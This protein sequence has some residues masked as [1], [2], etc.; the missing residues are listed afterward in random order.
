MGRDEQC[1]LPA[2]RIFDVVI[3]TE[4][5]WF[6]GPKGNLVF[7][8]HLFSFDKDEGTSVWDVATG[9]RLLRESSFCPQRYHPGTKSFLTVLPDD[10]FQISKLRGRTVELGWLSWNDRTVV[11]LA[12]AI[13]EEGAFD[14]LP[15]LADALE[16]AGCTDGEI[17][18][19]CRQ[20]NPHARTC[21][22]IDLLL[23][24]KD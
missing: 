22:V 15:I 10:G 12:H 1:L 18:G 6:P 20:A 13:Q 23:E 3:G 4:E 14:R 8:Q 11:Q 17:L 19:H 7:D 16:E 2:V 24:V 9:E 21:W 5:R